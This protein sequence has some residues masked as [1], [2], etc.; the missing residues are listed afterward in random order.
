MA[1][2]GLDRSDTLKE[3]VVNETLMKKL[4][5]KDPSQMIGR[6]LR[7]GS[8]AWNPVVGVV[9]DFKTNSLREDIK[10]LAIFSMSSYYSNIGVKLNG[11]EFTETVRDI[12][13]LWDKYF[14]EYVNNSRFMDEAIAEFYNQEEQLSRLYKIFAVLAIMISCLGL[15][16]LVSFMAAQKTKE[17]GIRKVLGA[18]T[19][20][21][22]FLFSKEFMVLIIIAFLIASPLA[23]MF[24]NSW[25]ENFTFRISIGPGVFLLAIVTT[26]LIAWVTVGFKAIKAATVSP[27]KSLK[28]E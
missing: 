21:I 16:G 20:S 9:K 25:L 23:F 2:R 26:L 5:I 18:S 19:S 14:P 17:V 28:S 22:V 27:V 15:Y 11:I 13:K 3:L 6:N 7:M 1:G 4:G 10:P 12:Q 24:M 8:G